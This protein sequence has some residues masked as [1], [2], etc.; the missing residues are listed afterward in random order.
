M[1]IC[2]GRTKQIA[3]HDPAAGTPFGCLVAR[4]AMAQFSA[5]F[6]AQHKLIGPGTIVQ[7]KNLTREIYQQ[8]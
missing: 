7:T 2:G 4:D 8:V 3:G 5:H 6:D 1:V